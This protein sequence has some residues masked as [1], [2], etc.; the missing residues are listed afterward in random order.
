[1]KQLL[2]LTG[3]SFL[4]CCSSGYAHEPVGNSTS[5]CGIQA[6]QR[7]THAIEDLDTRSAVREVAK[8]VADNIACGDPIPSYEWITP[9]RLVPSTV[10]QQ[11]LLLVTDHNTRYSIY[12]SAGYCMY[13]AWAGKHMYQ[14]WIRHYEERNIF[15]HITT[16]PVEF[17]EMRAQLGLMWN[18][19]AYAIKAVNGEDIPPLKMVFDQPPT[20]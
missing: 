17:P 2:L 6:V 19:K 14:E 18:E 10:I 8:I 3:I 20:T 13:V 16:T 7:L 1:M 4:V 12:S 11:G 15:Y 5:I 9:K